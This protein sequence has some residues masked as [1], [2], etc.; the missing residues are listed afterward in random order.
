[1]P[2]RLRPF[3][4]NLSAL[5]S[6]YGRLAETLRDRQRSP[7]TE[8]AQSSGLHKTE[9]PENGVRFSLAE[10]AG[11][12][13]NYDALVAG[14]E[15]KL[16]NPFDGLFF[17]GFP[18]RDLLRSTWREVRTSNRVVTIIEPNLDIL[19]AQ[20]E[21]G[22]FRE[23][24]RSRKL[25]LIAGDSWRD[26]LEECFNKHFL[27][28]IQHPLI[29]S[30]YLAPPRIQKHLGEA[31]ARVNQLLQQYGNE[32][33]TQLET[34]GA[35]SRR[36]GV[37]TGRKI[38]AH[39]DLRGKHSFTMVQYHLSR[40]L[41]R[42]MQ[43]QGWTVRFN[44]LRDDRFYPAY[45]R[46]AD[47]ARFEPDAILLFNESAA[48]ETVLGP[49]L[50]TRISV[51]KAVWWADN[52]LFCE[53]LF[54]R[55][56]IAQNELHAAADRAWL[57]FLQKKGCSERLFLPGASTYNRR[58]RRSA[59][60]ACHVSFVGQVRDQRAFFSALTPVWKEY[61]ERVVLLKLERRF[62]GLDEIMRELEPPQKKLR[63][64]YLDD[65]RQKLLWEAN[66]RYRVAT[67][68]ALAET[69]FLLFGNQDWLE[70]LDSDRSRRRFRGVIPYKNLPHLYRSSGVVLNIHSLQ[71]TTC[72]NVRDFDVP[73]AG[74]FLATDLLPGNEEQF[75][76]GFIEDLENDRS[77]EICAYRSHEELKRIVA[78]VSENPALRTA[79]IEKARA[80]IAKE[81]TYDCAYPQSSTT[82]RRV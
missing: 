64:D 58:G 19:A 62:N 77:R 15:A 39:L 7:E 68:K 1:M 67:L 72:H 79:W 37:Q 49:R 13:E 16:R 25:L 82:E 24:L 21:T 44:V 10:E 36:R 4:G 42:G 43:R 17:L 33:R 2:S 48:F 3:W 57:S 52:P 29:H 65:L 28:G 46:L 12:S 54:E 60:L 32:Y 63:A 38:W 78:A 14:L 30:G 34:L 61:C 81:H 18:N 50:G 8:I 20:L 6:R 70:F 69:D 11:S 5:R 41:L 73:M 31:A 80:R 71:A 9:L 40:H 76:I 26:E 75:D 22:D 74:G 23:E 35:G 45:Q 55:D 56:G 27:G 47:L 51:P 66:T 59:R 53:H